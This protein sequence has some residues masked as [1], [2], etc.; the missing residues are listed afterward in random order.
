MDHTVNREN[1][2][3][4]AFATQSQDI[5]DGMEDVCS[6]LRQLLQDAN[7]YM[8]DESGQ[9]ALS[10]IEELIEDISKTTVQMRTL[11]NQVKRSADLLEESDTLL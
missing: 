11:A 6:H 5:A 3:M 10:I 8:Q 2:A 4:K 9:E 1:I 7:D